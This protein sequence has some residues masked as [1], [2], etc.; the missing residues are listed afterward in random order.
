VKQFNYGDRVYWHDAGKLKLGVVH[1]HYK[2]EPLVEVTSL[3]A[4]L[5]NDDGTAQ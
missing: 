2:D 5:E 1:V 3:I 4:E